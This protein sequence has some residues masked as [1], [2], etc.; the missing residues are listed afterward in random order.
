MDWTPMKK[1]VMAEAARPASTCGV[2]RKDWGSRAKPF[3]SSTPFSTLTMTARITRP[4]TAMGR[5]GEMPK[6]VNGQAAKGS[7]R[8]QA[9]MRET[10]TRNRNRPRAARATPM[11]SNL[12]LPSFCSIS[13]SLKE[14]RN[15]MAK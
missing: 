4:R 2:L 13:G 10:P 12:S 5:H 11:P 8:P 9:E 15:T 7:M 3:F 6:M 1:K 14:S